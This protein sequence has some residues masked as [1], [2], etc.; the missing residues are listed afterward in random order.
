MILFAF[1]VGDG[2][3]RT[4]EDGT[5]KDDSLL[6]YTAAALVAPQRPNTDAPRKSCPPP[7]HS[8][9]WTA[10]MSDNVPSSQPNIRGIALPDSLAAVREETPT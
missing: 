8:T 10:P 5:T 4:S 9:C 1:I 2:F 7:T 6:T 3:I